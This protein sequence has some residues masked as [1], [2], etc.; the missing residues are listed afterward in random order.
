MK[1]DDGKK[2]GQ[3]M[4]WRYFLAVIIL[5]TV[6]LGVSLIWNIYNARQNTLKAARSEASTVFERNIIFRRWS[7]MHGGVYVAVDAGVQP[8]PYLADIPER[9]VVTPSGRTLTLLNPASIMR[10][11]YELAEKETGVLIR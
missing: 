7:A 8:N 3:V 9:D 5:W 6:I 2:L 10:Q 11:T 1:K 4:K